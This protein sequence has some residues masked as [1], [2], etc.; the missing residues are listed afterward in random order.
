MPNSSKRKYKKKKKEFFSLKQKIS[1]LF[2]LLLLISAFTYGYYL[3]G[4]NSNDLNKSK[5][6]KI[7][8]KEHK[9]K[10]HKT[11]AV[12]KKS[13][14]PK[15]VIIIDDV[16]TSLQLS[17]IKALGLRVTPSIFPPYT[18]A[19]NSN[20]LATNL[21][22]FMIH[23]PMESS[24]KQFNKQYKTL[25]VKHSE[26]SIENRIKELRVLFPNAKY[27]NNHTGSVFTSNYK[28]MSI[29]Y[30]YLKKY[31]FKFV[32]SKTS[33][34]TKV[35]EITKK[36]KD[37]YIARDIFLDNKKDIEYIKKQL[38]KA[39]KIAQKHGYAIAIG[40]PYSVTMR[41]LASSKNILDL[42][43]VIYID[44]LF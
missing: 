3:G 37:K 20:K 28:A 41:A 44:E 16:H 14:K 1:T 33:K 17:T 9:A 25:K 22:H 40:H 32:D 23:I 29:T 6:E 2:C 11:I 12:V 30:K 35:E 4:E 18:L 5:K 38:K 43:D 36:Y 39:V 8:H 7:L 21:K 31:N 42:V 10:P 19:P 34:N 13:T 27:T 24:S 26:K 15:L